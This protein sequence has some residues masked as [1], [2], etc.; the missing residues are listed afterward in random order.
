MTAGRRPPRRG[1]S[2]CHPGHAGQHPDPAKTSN[3]T[4]GPKPGTSRSA[5]ATRVTPESSRLGSKWLPNLNP[6]DVD[7]ACVT[8][9]TC[10]GD[11]I[12][13]LLERH[14]SSRQ[15]PVRPTR[16]DGKGSLAKPRRLPWQGGGR[17]GG[18][19]LSITIDQN[20]ETPWFGLSIVGNA[21]CVTYGECV[22]LRR[23]YVP[24]LHDNGSRNVVEPSDITIWIGV[25]RPDSLGE[26]SFEK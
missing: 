25:T 1:S 7:M 13:T 18:N 16:R 11:I 26:R 10:Q 20:T 3:Q 14:P 12:D 9:Q 8:T 6:V 15:L 23:R 19:G 24:H 5:R 2:P 21:I 22:L 17:T 4:P